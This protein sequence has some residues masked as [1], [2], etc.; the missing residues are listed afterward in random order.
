MRRFFVPVSGLVRKG[1]D[2]PFCVTVW[3]SCPSLGM[4]VY[5]IENKEAN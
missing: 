1:T 3:E 5:Y 2:V 4:A